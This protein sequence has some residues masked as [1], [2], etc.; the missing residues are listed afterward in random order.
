[1]AL[2]SRGSEVPRPAA[3]FSG[4]QE[5]Q[6]ALLVGALRD[7]IQFVSRAMRAATA[8]TIGQGHGLCFF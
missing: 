6:A 8:V 1:M 5:P 4:Q 2:S 3:L 7:G